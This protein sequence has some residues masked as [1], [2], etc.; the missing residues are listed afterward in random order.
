MFFCINAC[1][2]VRVFS[3]PV[4][5]SLCMYGCTETPPRDANSVL[6]VL[7][8]YSS[9]SF[10]CAILTCIVLGTWLFYFSLL[11]VNNGKV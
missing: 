8:S 9:I 4:G 10:S 3:N 11:A 2:Y 6:D 1:K 5:Y 7:S